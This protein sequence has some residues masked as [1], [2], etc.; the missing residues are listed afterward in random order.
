MKGFNLKSKS[1]PDI[2]DII[3]E[4]ADAKSYCIKSILM[5]TYTLDASQVNNMLIALAAKGL[6]SLRQLPETAVYYHYITS[7]CSRILGSDSFVSVGDK[8]NGKSFHP[9]ITLLRLAKKSDTPDETAAD[10]PEKY[11]LVV[12]SR[13]ITNSDNL[14]AYA[15]LEGSAVEQNSAENPPNGA[16]LWAFLEKMSGIA[17]AAAPQAWSELARVHFE[18]KD[19]PNAS[20]GFVTAENLGE[21][22]RRL[23]DI[24]VVSPFLG[25]E[26]R[27]YNIGSVL[28]TENAFENLKRAFP[29]PQKIS[30]PPQSGINRALQKSRTKPKK[31]RSFA[32]RPDFYYLP[33]AE[34]SAISLHAKIYCGLNEKGNSVL[35][36]GSSNATFRGGLS[37]QSANAVNSEFNALLRFD[38]EAPCG[39]MHGEFKRIIKCLGTKYYFRPEKQTAAAKKDNL[40][41][42]FIGFS[43]ALKITRLDLE[44]STAEFSGKLPDEFPNHKFKINGIE[45]SSSTFS[46]EVGL[47]SLFSAEVTVSDSENTRSFFVD[48]LSICPNEYKEILK[49]KQDNAA[50]A[51]RSAFSAGLI[52]RI[53]S[54]KSAAFSP[55]TKSAKDAQSGS[56]NGKSRAASRNCVF[57]KLMTLAKTSGG[58]DRFIANLKRINSLATDG[59]WEE[60]TSAFLEKARAEAGVNPTEKEEEKCDQTDSSRKPS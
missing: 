58:R 15:V 60:A 59:E 18:A 8:M 51:N 2:T 24:T 49:E 11:L 37:S 26:L 4:R 25:D 28:S 32:P 27:G 30:L 12:S 14:E 45:V 29:K 39:K 13:N 50:R 19:H 23:T 57:E 17:H 55:E 16:A 21:E 38:S 35:I 1:Y 9:K 42:A 47:S 33:E 56:E 53:V 52:E 7:D 34:G 10:T 44:S 54:G 5:T 22:L 46:M 20:V 48:L 36:I 43:A 31:L 3:C 6:C 41:N 40:L